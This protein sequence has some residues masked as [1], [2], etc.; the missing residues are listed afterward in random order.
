VIAELRDLFERYPGDAEFVLEMHT[1][2]G[3]RCLRFGDGFKVAGRDA[4]LK[5]EL[6]DLLG[7]ALAREPAAA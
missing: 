3:V 7:P 6:Q 4:G 1:R 2:A 5:A